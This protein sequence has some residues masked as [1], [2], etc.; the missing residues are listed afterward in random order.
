MANRK[1]RKSSD[2]VNK[3]IKW[4]ML[5]WVIGSG[6]LFFL[7][8]TGLSRHD[9]V[10]VGMTIIIFGV[11]GSFL[12]KFLLLRNRSKPP[13]TQ[14]GALQPLIKNRLWL[15]TAI[16]IISL[17]TLS[18]M[19][20]WGFRKF[21]PFPH[22]E[23][24]KVVEEVNQRVVYWRIEPSHL[25]FT[26]S[27]SARMKMQVGTG[28]FGCAETPKAQFVLSIKDIYKDTAYLFESTEYTLET[29]GD[30]TKVSTADICDFINNHYTGKYPLLEALRESSFEISDPRGIVSLKLPIGGVTVELAYMLIKIIKASGSCA[31]IMVKGYADGK[32][33]EW[34][35]ELS[36]GR[37]H[38]KEIPVYP[39]VDPGSENPFK[40]F[41]TVEMRTVPEVY[42]NQD[43]PN[44]RAMFVKENLIIPFLSDCN[45]LGNIQVSILDGYEYARWS[46]ME[47]KVQVYLVL[48]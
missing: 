13:Q 40:Y 32:V 9:L 41:R 21:R 29:G 5:F 1:P 20:I 14:A 35:R 7:W 36:P 31:E 4:L 23:V 17:A 26:S 8:Y 34:G 33:T 42:T 16:M 10:Q 25:I 45:K 27:R 11:V 24:N 28:S 12:I 46:P 44:L 47:R 19:L 48:F 15:V 38:Y 6:Y 22:E 39:K 30:L 2:Q 3:L 37:Y 18:L 43:L